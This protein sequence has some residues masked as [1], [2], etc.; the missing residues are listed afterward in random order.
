MKPVAWGVLSASSH[1]SVR[2]N[3]WLQKSPQLT[4]LAIASR[5]ADGAREAAARLGIPRAYG[6]YQELLADPEVEAVYIPLPNHLHAPWVKKALDAGKHVL[7][8][9]PFALTAAEAQDAVRHAEARGLLVMEGFMYKFHPAWVRALQACRTGEIG[10]IH[11]VHCR[12]TYPLH[13]P[14]NIRNQPAAGG[15]SLYDVGSYA[16]SMPRF[17]LGAEPSR[18]VSLMRRDPAL[19]TDVLSSGMLDF[20]GAHALFTVATQSA[21]GQSMRV[22]GSGGELWI[23]IPINAYPDAP[24]LLTIVSGFGPRTLPMP[25]CDQYTLMFES[26]SRAIRTGGKAP[27]PG[28]D[29][30]ANMRALDALFRS[31]RSGGWEAV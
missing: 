29:A 19:G 25:V 13:D 9:K 12:F 18:V 15:G 27:V 17:L 2:L 31:E 28:A 1:F 5:S 4:I 14:R 6:G 10:E 26:F 23:D 30:V 11:A 8:E 20:G 7:C 21:G 16:V 3:P 24:G 22:I